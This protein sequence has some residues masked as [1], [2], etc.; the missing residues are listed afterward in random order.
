MTILSMRRR[1]RQLFECAA[2]EYITVSKLNQANRKLHR[3]QHS[4]NLEDSSH[5]QTACLADETKPAVLTQMMAQTGAPSFLARP[6][7]SC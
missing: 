5:A 6:S 4:E 7:T 2:G 1:V 3:F